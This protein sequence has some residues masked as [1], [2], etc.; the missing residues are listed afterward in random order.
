MNRILGSSILIFLLL[1]TSCSFLKLLNIGVGQESVKE[2]KFDFCS[3]H[4]I[5]KSIKLMLSNNPQYNLPLNLDSNLLIHKYS[6]PGSELHKRWNADSVNFHFTVISEQ[7]TFLLWTRFSGLM[8][9]WEV[10]SA[11]IVIYGVSIN[12]SEWKQ[13]GDKDF[14]RLERRRAIN[15]FE[16]E[17]LPKINEYLINDCNNIK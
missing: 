10:P 2:Y 8:N 15:L 16:L 9:N 3:K 4:Q 12:N 13:Q 1:L 11:K 6:S 5:Y 14:K 7:D 17:I